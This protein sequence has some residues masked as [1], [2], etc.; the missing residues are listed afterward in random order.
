MAWRVGRI[1]AIVGLEWEDLVR[2]R[3]IL[4]AAIHGKV[5]T[6]LHGR[7]LA[8]LG[9]RL[10]QD[11][12]WQTEAYQRLHVSRQ[13]VLMRVT[14]LA[15]EVENYT[16]LIGRVVQILGEHDEVAGC[17]VGRP[18]GQGVFRFESVSG[19]TIE[20]YLAELE[21][22]AD[23]PIADG[24]RPQGQGPAG[25]AWR[26][27]NV[28]RSVNVATD[29]LMAPWKN[30]ALREGFRS[31][32]AIPLRQPGHP[33]KAILSLYSAFPGGYSAADQIAFITP[34]Q[35]LLGLAIAR[36]ESQEGRTHAVPYATR[37]HWAALLRSDALEMHYQPLLDLKTGQITKV[38]ALARLHDGARVLTPGEF[39][40]ALS[41]DDFL[42]LYVRGLAQVLSQRNR[43]LQ[44]GVELKVSVNL[45][46]SA[47]GDNRYFEATREAL[48]DHACRPDTLTLEILETDAL[49]A[50]T[51]VRN[52]LAKFKL[53][54]VNLAEDD[55]GSG[56]SSLIRLRELPFDWIKIDRSIV[57]GVSEDASNVLRFVY[58]LT[59]LGRSL[60]K[61]VV[62][63]GIE[64]AGMLEAIV[65]LGAD[66]AQGYAIARPMPALQLMAWVS[67]SQP[68][69]PQPFEARSTLGKL[70][71]LLIW[72]ERLHL[73]CEDP[74]AF[75][76]LSDIMTMSVKVGAVAP[77]APAPLDSACQVCPFSRF[78]SETDSILPEGLSDPAA[79]RA[80]IAAAVSDGQDSVAY[81]SARARLVTAIMSEAVQH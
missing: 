72:E 22:S 25:R 81:R 23:R 71:T 43:W 48:T 32:V 80:L 6:M 29:P 47:L 52:E 18:D 61:S 14:A 9:R 58:Q 44:G 66:V 53:L 10:T 36:I 1:H 54:G 59:R 34:L 28:E 55:L 67:N 27:G 8:V 70:A 62:V 16:D 39:F 76:W 60:G 4:S 77:T 38:E 69:L 63:E 20:R 68:R 46:S 56:H 35:T 57:S 26:S 33:P 11:L 30:V 78:F 37:Q 45:P 5:D 65:I 79:Q 64:D 3:G 2:S 49:P 12:A 19:K 42:V 73:I 13:D 75:G 51:D 21:G 24:D 31:S 50:G 15:W 17:S 41:S 40:P 74:R 7:A